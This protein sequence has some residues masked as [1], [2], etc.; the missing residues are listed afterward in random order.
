LHALLP[1]THPGYIPWGQYQRNQ[2]RLRESVQAHDRDGRQSPAGEGP[3][4]L[5]G[6]V[7]CGRC[8]Q[9]MTL[10]YH[11]R[12]TGLCPNYLCQREGIEHASRICQNIP[13][14][15]LDAAIGALLLEML[16]PV[17]L[18]VALAVQQELQQRL[19]ETDR[20]RRQ[21]VERARYEAD[22]AQQR[23]MQVDPNN[24]FV[25]DALEADW[26]DKLRA[27]TQAQEDYEQQRRADRAVLDESGRQQLLALSC[28]KPS[29]SAFRVARRR[30]SRPG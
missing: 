22:L 17:T 2:Q 15:A 30:R 16:M 11:T 6:L 19:D 24:R 18:E 3:A 10:R 28:S 9:G 14:A 20:L 7:L 21:Q 27:L 1:E 23:Y 5:Q 4:L 12:K 13:G 8:G 25:A 26:N 29:T